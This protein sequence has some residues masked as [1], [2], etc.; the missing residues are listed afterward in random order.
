[1]MMSN[2]KILMEKYLK[3]KK[4]MTMDSIKKRMIKMKKAEEEREKD[5]Q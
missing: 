2:K 5:K 4:N 1:M 3:R